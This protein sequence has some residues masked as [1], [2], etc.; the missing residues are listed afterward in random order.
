MIVNTSQEYSNH[1]LRA[2]I[3]STRRM[4]QRVVL[5]AICVLL[6][7]APLIVS[8]VQNSPPYA[9]VLGPYK[10]SLFDGHRCLPMIHQYTQQMQWYKDEPGCITVAIVKGSIPSVPHS[11]DVIMISRD[12]I[13]P[14]LALN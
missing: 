14:S 1:N 10:S 3:E 8:A 12:T 4:Q 6:A 7:I 11:M 9:V 5:A 2:S 13:V